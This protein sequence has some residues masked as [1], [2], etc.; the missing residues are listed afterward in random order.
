MDVIPREPVGATCTMGVAPNSKS[1]LCSVQGAG[2]DFQSS[3]RFET[4]VCEG[5]LHQYHPLPSPKEALFC[6]PPAM[7]ALLVD[8]GV[9]CS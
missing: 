1:F 6:I 2:A 9:G 8:T 4:R 7:E 5:S 3:I